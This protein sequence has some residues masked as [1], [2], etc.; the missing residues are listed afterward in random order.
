MIDIVAYSIRGT[1]ISLVEQ[2]F[3]C[4]ILQY[5]TN[6]WVIGWSF[7]NWYGRRLSHPSR[8]GAPDDLLLCLLFYFLK[9][10]SATHWTEEFMELSIVMTGECPLD[11]IGV[12]NLNVVLYK[13]LA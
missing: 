7:N 5:N 4:Q 1:H 12:H 11:V 10:Y 9:I 13:S 3:G 6:E 8:S 2:N